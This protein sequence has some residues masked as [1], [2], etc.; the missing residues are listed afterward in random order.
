MEKE[1]RKKEAKKPPPS[2]G[3]F[4]GWGSWFSGGSS[5]QQSA[6]LSMDELLGKVEEALTPGEK[7]K[8]Y[9][10]IDYTENALPLDYPNTF[11]EYKLDFK[12]VKL[13]ATVREFRGREQAGR[14]VLRLE[15]ADVNAQYVQISFC[16]TNVL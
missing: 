11:I 5:P 3:W 9:A 4:S 7:A 6:E 2:G 15:V 16:S 14:K 13:T 8:L 12:L 10:A 1:G